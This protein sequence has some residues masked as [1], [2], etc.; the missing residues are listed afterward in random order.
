MIPKACTFLDGSAFDGCTN[1]KAVNVE[2]GNTAYYSVGGI[3]YKREDE[4]QHIKP[5]GSGRIVTVSFYDSTSHE[6]TVKDFD[7]FEEAVSVEGL[8]SVANSLEGTYYFYLHR[9]VSLAAD[10]TFPNFVTSVYFYGEDR[11]DI[12]NG[13]RVRTVVQTQIDLN[14]HKLC[15]G[16]L[17]FSSSAIPYNSDEQNKSLIK[18]T[19]TK[20]GNVTFVPVSYDR[21]AEG[22]VA[23]KFAL[24]TGR[25]VAVMPQADG[26]G[27]EVYDDSCWEILL[28]NTD[29]EAPIGIYVNN[30]AVCMEGFDSFSYDFTTN[31]F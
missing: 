5:A 31:V 24:P 11:I 4:T 21:Q 6:S 22:Y 27:A 17:R 30:A 26:T 1:L 29:V 7:T 19:D 20:N 14:G 12:V 10:V 25:V 16:N 13:N 18:A 15:G 2:D 23:G 8:K 9:D 28:Q 3:V